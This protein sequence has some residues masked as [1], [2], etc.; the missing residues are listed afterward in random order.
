MARQSYRISKCQKSL[1]RINKRIKSKKLI[2]SKLTL[3][4]VIVE[5][6]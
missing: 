2:L 5:V 4:Q 1:R 3:I 6:Q